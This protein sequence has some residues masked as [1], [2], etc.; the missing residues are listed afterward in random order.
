MII[1][2]ID[3]M[4]YNYDLSYVKILRLLRVLRIIRL[5]SHSDSMKIVINSIFRVYYNSYKNVSRLE[6]L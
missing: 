1:S 5:I 4:L 2:L 6:E 3:I